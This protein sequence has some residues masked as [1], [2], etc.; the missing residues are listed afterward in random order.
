MTTP[1]SGPDASFSQLIHQLHTE[2]LQ[3]DV[4]E[5]WRSRDVAAFILSTESSADY[6]VEVVDVEGACLVSRLAEVGPRIDYD[7][8][9]APK[10]IFRHQGNPDSTVRVGEIAMFMGIARRGTAF[11]PDSV[12]GTTPITSIIY[13]PRQ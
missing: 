4:L 9:R 8:P 12:Y 3:V 1:L 5:D 7:G 13:L 11:D 10:V 2:G 6:L